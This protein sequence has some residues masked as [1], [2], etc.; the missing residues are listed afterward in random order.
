MKFSKEFQ[1]PLDNPDDE[2]LNVYIWCKAPPD[3]DLP[4]LENR[5]IL[6]G[7]VSDSLPAEPDLSS[8]AG[9]VGHD[10][11]VSNPV[12]HAHEFRT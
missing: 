8:T 1:F 7:Y 12:S 4:L 2:Y 9:V 11:V 3:F 5:S 6:L 10:I